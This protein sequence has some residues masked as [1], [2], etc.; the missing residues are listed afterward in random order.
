MPPSTMTRRDF[1]AASLTGLAA[2]AAAPGRV[3]RSRLGLVIHSYGTHVAATRSQPAGERFDDPFR[4]LDYADQ[5]RFS[6]VQVALGVLDNGRAAQLRDQAERAG[7]ALEGIVRLPRQQG[8]LGAFEAALRTARAAG[9][10]IVRTV[11]LDGRRYEVFDSADDFR[12]FRENARLALSRAL[13]L[14]ER[15]GVKLAVE[16][17]KDLRAAE[18]IAL[19]KQF[20]SE[21]LGVCLDTGNSIALLED[22][23]EVVEALA[24]W[25]LTTH[26][27]DMA[28]TLDPDGFLLSEVPLGTGYLDLARIMRTVQGHR[29]E[30]RFN[31]EMITRDPLR[32]PCLT[33]RYWATLSELKGPVLARALRAVRAHAHSGPLPR[34]TDR[35]QSERLA[36]EEANVRECL[37]YARERLAAQ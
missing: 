26:F 23:M 32:V 14:A 25:A 18:Q 19:L 8:D 16:N 7:V 33:E 12:E 30:V 31:L 37:A 20:D 28:V 10:T 24:P 15:I 2:L 3:P 35:D 1:L 5:R 11:L 21:F 29:P 22:P 13:P 17:H 9:V 27:K 36:I 6:A 34:V 4:F